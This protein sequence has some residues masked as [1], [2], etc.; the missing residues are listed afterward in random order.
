MIAINPIKLTEEIE[1]IKLETLLDRTQLAK[2]YQ[3]GRTYIYQVRRD[4]KAWTATLRKLKLMWV[5]TNKII[6]NNVWK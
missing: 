3:I 2:R 6:I 1:R 4:G 5:D